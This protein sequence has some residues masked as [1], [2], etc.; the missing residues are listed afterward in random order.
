MYFLA[1]V[2]FILILYHLF[3]DDSPYVFENILK[4]KVKKKPYISLNE[5]INQ[6]KKT[7]NPK[8]SIQLKKTIKNRKLFWFYFTLFIINFFI[9]SYRSLKSTAPKSQEVSNSEQ[10][11]TKQKPL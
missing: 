2:F 8:H 4:V 5:M 3:N 11:V 1:I 10:V 7:D 9:I 6:L